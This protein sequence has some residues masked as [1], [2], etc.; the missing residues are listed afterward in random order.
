MKPN[1]IYTFQDGALFDV[2]INNMMDI[3]RPRDFDGRAV[4]S[5]AQR[6]DNIVKYLRNA[7]EGF[8]AVS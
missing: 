2:P 6:P 7:K 5:T 3:P 1:S 4:I 8:L